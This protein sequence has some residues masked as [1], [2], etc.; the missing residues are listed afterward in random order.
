MN[1]QVTRPGHMIPNWRDE[2]GGWADLVEDTPYEAAR[3]ARAAL[4]LQRVQWFALGACGG[5]FAV[6]LG[7]IF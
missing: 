2:V 7:L 4:W 6:W 5:C 3:E 1:T